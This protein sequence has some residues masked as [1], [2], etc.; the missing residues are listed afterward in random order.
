L[1]NEAKLNYRLLQSLIANLIKWH[2]S[3]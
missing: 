2:Y 3:T 1:R